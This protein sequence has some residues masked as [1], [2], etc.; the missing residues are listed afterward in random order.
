MADPMQALKMV[1][2][3]CVGTA[4]VEISVNSKFDHRKETKTE[5]GV[6]P[7][8]RESY[9]PPKFQLQIFCRYS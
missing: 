8:V 3:P 5:D 7:I 1:N 6:F 4:I 9:F 2:E